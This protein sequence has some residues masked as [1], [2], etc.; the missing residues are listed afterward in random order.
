MPT[1]NFAPFDNRLLS[2][3][4]PS[5]LKSVLNSCEA[6]QLELSA[7]LNQ[8][9][10]CIAHVYFPLNS[11]ISLITAVDGGNSLEVS[12][13]GNEGMLGIPLLL[14]E[15]NSPLLAQVQGGGQA[16]RMSAGRFNQALS[17]NPT[18]R[19]CL[20][21][22]AHVVMIQLAQSIACVR[23][24]FLEARLA[25]WLLM[26]HDRA[27]TDEFHVTQ[28]FLSHMLG[29]RRVGITNAATVLQGRNLIRYHRGQLSI[30]DRAGLEAIACPCY[31]ID[32]ESYR[33]VLG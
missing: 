18:L 32:K 27:H 26:S 11:F 16:L 13:V 33:L 19:H 23:F 24:H 20:L 12:M 28:V 8:P 31:R 25:R 17:G 9:G 6:V 5:E 3:L 10:S 30:V 15:N 1:T 7:C 4:P 29:V 22:Y 2:G 21:R 14:G